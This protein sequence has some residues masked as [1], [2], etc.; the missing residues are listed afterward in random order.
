M[1]TQLHF[2]TPRQATLYASIT[3]EGTPWSSIVEY[4]G[5]QHAVKN[6]MYVRGELQGLINAKLV[7]R[8]SDIHSEV[9]VRTNG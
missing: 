4:V 3:P 9:Y 5:K 6:W 2:V 7:K 8:T 1:N